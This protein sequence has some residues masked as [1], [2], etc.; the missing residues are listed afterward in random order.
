MR[1]EVEGTEGLELSTRL[2]IAE[3]VARG[4][5]VEVLDPAT[6]FIRIRGK[7]KVEYIRQATMT[8]ADRYVVPLIMENKEITK[9]LLREAGVRTPAGAAYASLDAALAAAGDWEGRPLVVKPNS[10]NY[11]VGVT[12]LPGPADR[13]AVEAALRRAFGAS[14][15]DRVIAEEYVAGPEYRF[16]VIGGRVRAVL[17]RLPAN[18]MGDGR[19]TIEELVAEKNSDPRR[20]EGYARPLERIRLGEVELGMLAR[21]GMSPSSV[22]RARDRVWLRENSNISTGGDSVD[23]TDD[24]PAAYKEIAEAAAEVVGARICGVDMI[25]PDKDATVVADTTVVADGAVGAGGYSVI[26]LNFNPALHIHDYPFQG[27]DR[28]VERHVLDL[29]GL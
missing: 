9:R 12:V 17:R 5:R 22:P 3:A 8:A 16:L 26:E 10:T 15:G 19:S 14:P 18:V 2:V 7:G 13:A 20:G 28:Q 1:Y 4:H 21:R 23:H 25:V 24:M 27:E 11:G 29:L 6:C